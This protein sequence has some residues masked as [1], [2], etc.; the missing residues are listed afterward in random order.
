MDVVLLDGLES[1]CFDQQA[2]VADLDRREAI[3]AR[4]VHGPFQSEVRV[5]AGQC[6]G[7]IRHNGAGWIRDLPGDSRLVSLSEKPGGCSQGGKHNHERHDVQ[8]LALEH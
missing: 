5:R 2:V 3:A 1:L 7:G 6:H 8:A 4:P